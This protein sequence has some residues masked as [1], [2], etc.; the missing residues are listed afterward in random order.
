MI[1]DPE[2]ELKKSLPRPPKPFE[3]ASRFAIIEW[4]EA[5]GQLSAVGVRLAFSTRHW[6]GTPEQR[7]A[8]WSKYHEVERQAQQ[9][10]QAAEEKRQAEFREKI[11]AATAKQNKQM[12]W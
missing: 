9:R 5:C 8:L 1:T 11:R 12:G 10:E 4:L 7:A 6:P 3:S 2:M